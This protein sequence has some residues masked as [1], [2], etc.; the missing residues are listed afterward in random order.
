MTR[1]ILALL[2]A[3]LGTAAFGAEEVITIPTRNGVTLSYL[4][5][6]DK[7][8]TPKIVVISFVGGYGAIDLV[9]R[10]EGHPP[11]FGPTANFLVRIR[12]QV[13]DLDMADVIVDS[14][15]DKLPQGMPDDF[16]LGP[17]HLADIRALIADLKKRF[18]N[19]KVYLAGTSRGTISSAALSAKLGDSVQGVVLTS[20]VTNRDKTGEALS[21]FDF[22]TIKIPVLLVHHRDDGCI[23][24]P[25]SGAERLS[26]SFPLVSV[27]GGDPPQSQPCEAVSAHG[28]LG[29]EAQVT[30]AMKSWMLGREFVRDIR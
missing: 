24:S 22:A 4:L 20:T 25:Y 18:P 19:A 15:S 3:L 27:S 17:D 16:R 6:Q 5:V 29:R 28:Y 10:S 2:C 7:S 21:R 12:D 11:R 9:K 14:P 1:M 8:A 13:A 26:K 30:Q 23:T